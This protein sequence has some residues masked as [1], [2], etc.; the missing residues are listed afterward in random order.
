MVVYKYFARK[1]RFVL[2][3]IHTCG[4]FLSKQEVKAARFLI[5]HML[6]SSLLSAGLLANALHLNQL[7]SCSVHMYHTYTYPVAVLHAV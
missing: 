1:D 2:P 5:L 3:T 4:R 7:H 6:Q